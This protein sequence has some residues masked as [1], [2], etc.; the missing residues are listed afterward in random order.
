M[1]EIN[2]A[3]KL[4]TKEYQSIFVNWASGIVKIIYEVCINKPLFDC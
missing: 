1:C 4:R 2:L 3:F